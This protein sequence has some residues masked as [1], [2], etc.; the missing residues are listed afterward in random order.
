MKIHE[1]ITR[2][3]TI[4]HVEELEDKTNKDRGELKWKLKNN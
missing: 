1:Q 2:Q 3:E 4:Y